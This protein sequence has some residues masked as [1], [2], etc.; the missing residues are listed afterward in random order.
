VTGGYWSVILAGIGLAGLYLAG[1][2]SPW[3]WALGL[4]DELLWIIYGAVTGQWAFC[5]SALAYGWVYA[6]NLRASRHTQRCRAVTTGAARPAWG[7][8]PPDTSP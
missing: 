7:T 8:A 1:R 4:V 3:G 5:L 2:H 6:H